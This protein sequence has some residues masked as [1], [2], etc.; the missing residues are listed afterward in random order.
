MSTYPADVK[1]VAP[2]EERWA[3]PHNLEVPSLLVQFMVDSIVV[4]NAPLVLIV[5]IEIH[6]LSAGEGVL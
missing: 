6:E 5:I 1:V 2:L 4:V 3:N